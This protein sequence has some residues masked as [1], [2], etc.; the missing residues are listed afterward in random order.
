MFKS[1]SH[2]P[3]SMFNAKICNSNIT[4]LENNNHLEDF[5]GAI[6]YHALKLNTI[7]IIGQEHPIKS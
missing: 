1:F 2:S 4:F 5:L 3:L 6:I 7:K